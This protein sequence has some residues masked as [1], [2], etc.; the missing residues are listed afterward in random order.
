[1]VVIVRVRIYLVVIPGSIWGRTKVLHRKARRDMR[2]PLSE[3][4]GH[5]LL[6]HPKS[7]SQTLDGGSDVKVVH[8]LSRGVRH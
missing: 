8:R 5:S 2:V 3:H 1:L 4:A 6:R 7:M